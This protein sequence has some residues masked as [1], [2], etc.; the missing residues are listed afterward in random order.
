MRP[1]Y[2]GVGDDARPYYNSAPI[3]YY[4]SALIVSYYNSASNCS[5]CSKGPYYNSAT[6]SALSVHA[7]VLFEYSGVDLSQQS[8]DLEDWLRGDSSGGAGPQRVLIWHLQEIP[9][10]ETNTRARW[11]PH[12]TRIRGWPRCLENKH[13][14]HT[15]TSRMA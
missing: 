1:R 7:A 2:A 4:N 6:D 5:S 14:T 8:P 13:A 12:C 11:Q 9:V 10:G 15:G 3:S